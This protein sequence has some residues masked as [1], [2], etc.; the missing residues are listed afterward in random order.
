[1]VKSAANTDR[2]Q[3]DLLQFRTSSTAADEC[4]RTVLTYQLGIT[5]RA[6]GH[7]LSKVRVCVE[8]T[9]IAFPPHTSSYDQATSQLLLP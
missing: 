2:S 4:S 5:R 8:N 3:D 1:M 9:R 6:I 7:G